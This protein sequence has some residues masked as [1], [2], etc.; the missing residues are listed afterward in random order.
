MGT[1]A[2]RQNS[3]K[4]FVTEFSAIEY[5]CDLQDENKKRVDMSQGCMQ[6]KWKTINLN[7]F[8]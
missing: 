4:N 3:A 7:Y 6:I 1:E 2:I 5:E 8:T